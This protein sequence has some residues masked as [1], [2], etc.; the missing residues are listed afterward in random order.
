MRYTQKNVTE[1]ITDKYLFITVYTADNSGEMEVGMIYQL[2]NESLSI[3]VS[4]AG[5]ELQSIYSRKLDREYLW[6]AAPEAW[7]NH[8]L[9]LF[10]ATGRISRS[11]VFVRGKEYPLP[12][13][14]FAK[15]MD[16]TLVKQTD[17]ILVLELTDTEE[18]LRMFPYPF[19]LQVEF[20]LKGDTVF[21]RFSVRNT[22]PGDMFFSLGAHPGFYCPIVLGESAGDYLLVF[23]R[24]QTVDKIILEP[25]TRLCTTAREPMLKDS[26]ELPL[27][28]GFFNGGPI[29]SEGYDAD[30]IEIR[31][32]KSGHRIR[33]GIKDFPYI[34]FWG[35]AHQ[36][37]LICI[38]PWCGLSDFVGT[39]HIWEKKPAGNRLSPGTV[40]YRELFFQPGRQTEVTT[41]R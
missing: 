41:G 33:I 7:G 36:M 37:S 29:L 23:D 32:R 6:Q 11:R 34:T 12:M 9:L 10:P 40:F 15:D 13:H 3:R 26:S 31:S 25:H 14:G 22:G 30:W 2:H 19:S 17:Q 18:T 39:D 21:Q 4:T 24:P 8:S 20:S 5:A 16:F 35:V 1:N 27:F 28:E 38:E